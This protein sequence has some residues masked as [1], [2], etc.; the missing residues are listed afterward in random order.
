MSG[1]DSAI[2]IGK[3]IELRSRKKISQKSI[4]KKGFII[5]RVIL[6]NLF[7]LEPLV[8]PQHSL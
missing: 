5:R 2:N 7:S 6:C 1:T 8:F 4:Q 3:I